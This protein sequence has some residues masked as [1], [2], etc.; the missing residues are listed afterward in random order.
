MTQ[1]C[2]AG[3]R[4]APVTWLGVVAGS[5]ATATDGMLLEGRARNAG[6]EMR[7]GTVQNMDGHT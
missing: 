5:H 4:L 1:N 6:M 7:R 2:K 3:R